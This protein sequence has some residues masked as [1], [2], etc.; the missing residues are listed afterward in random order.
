M[1]DLSTKYM[2]LSLRN[3]LVVASS[4]MTGSLDGVMQAAAA[5]AGAVVL[6]SLF[7]EQIAAETS[8]LGK[9]ADYAGHTE[10]AE[11]LQGYGMELG[12]QEYLQLISDSV[13]AVEIPVIASLNCFSYNRWAD[14]AQKI[15]AAGAAGLE[16]NI[17]LLPTRGGQKGRAI[18]ER[19]YQILHEVKTRIKIPVAL[20][21]GP[22]FSSFGEVAE[23]LG[24]DRAEA[25]PFTVGWCGPGENTTRITWRKADALVLFNRFYQ[26]DIDIDNI[27]LVPG[28][29]LSTSAEITTA[30][31]WIALLHKRIESDLA[32]TTG[33]HQGRDVIK[34]LLAGATVVQVCSTLMKNGFT[35]LGQ[36]LDDV[37]EWMKNHQFSRIDQFRGR[38]SQAQSEEPEKYE[39]LQYIKLF[40]GLE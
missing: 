24:H 9:H 22:Y 38:L 34:Q 21:I 36:I 19:Y 35:H 12:P 3:P 5:G 23:H 14:Y 17:G 27:E 33:I 6:K 28:N 7:E 2:G 31:R 18:E 20:K 4:S 13:K 37:E 8:A 25:P 10:A 30:L 11:Y 26:L 39:R 32:A 29:P 15:E 16:L 40:V 1:I